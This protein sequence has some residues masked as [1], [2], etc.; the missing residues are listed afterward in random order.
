MFFLFILDMITKG[1]IL[2][3][4]QNIKDLVRYDTDNDN[5]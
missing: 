1:F 5:I 3:E 4:G 2:V